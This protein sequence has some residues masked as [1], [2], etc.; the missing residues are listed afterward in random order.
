LTL[1]ASL[2]ARLDRLG[3]AKVVAQIAAVL[4]RE[5]AYPLIRAVAGSSETVLAA[6]L[7]R[8]AERT[9]FML[10]ACR[11]IPHTASSIRWC[12]TPPMRAC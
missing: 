8:L 7:E 12:R 2:T 5:F 1:H 9:L 3:S 4:G 11:R 6:A 10:K